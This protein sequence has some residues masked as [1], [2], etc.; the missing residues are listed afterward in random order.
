MRLITAPLTGSLLAASV[1]AVKGFYPQWFQTI[2]F[3]EEGLLF[4]AGLIAGI[5][6]PDIDL[7]LPGFS[8]RSGITHSCGFAVLFMMLGHDAIAGGLAIGIALHLSSDMQPKSWAGGALIKLPFFGSIGMLSPVWMLLHIAGCFWILFS[9]SSAIEETRRWLPLLVTLM[10]IVWY[11]LYE[12]KKRLLPLMTLG[13]CILL[14][15]QYFDGRFNVEVVV[16]YF[17]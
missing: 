12:E 3:M 13:F 11:F 16:Q 4:L 14:V 10:G 1:Y 8:H 15:H 9:V 5:R 7:L 6:L 2:A 17:V